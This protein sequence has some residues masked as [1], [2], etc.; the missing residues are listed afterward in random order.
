M[1]ELKPHQPALCVAPLPSGG[2]L[3]IFNKGE[4]PTNEPEPSDVLVFDD[5][6]NG[7]PSFQILES[8]R[9]KGERRKREI[10]QAIL[11]YD[12]RTPSDPPWRRSMDS[13]LREWNL[14][15]LAFILHVYRRS[16]RHVDLD[17]RDEGKGYAHFFLVAAQR[18]WEKLC[19][20]FRRA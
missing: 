16:A 15:N 2:R 8:H 4:T 7:N 17:N 19:M 11:D 14:H 20:A 6:H 5:R 10:L 3:Y 13:L 9:V 1:N 18:V 12:A